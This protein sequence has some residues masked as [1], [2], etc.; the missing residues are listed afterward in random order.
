MVAELPGVQVGAEQGACVE[1]TSLSS[2]VFRAPA[3]KIVAASL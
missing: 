1:Y 3:A 2:F